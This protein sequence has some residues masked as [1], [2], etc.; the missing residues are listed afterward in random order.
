MQ[1]GLTRLFDHFWHDVSWSHYHI[2]I[3]R[4]HQNV[5]KK[6]HCAYIISKG[7]IVFCI[8]LKWDEKYALEN[9]CQSIEKSN[10]AK[11]IKSQG[12]TVDRSSRLQICIQ[13]EGA[14]VRRTEKKLVYKANYCH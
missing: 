1:N 5:K 10:S 11:Y 14:K 8:V 3:Y 9:S 7:F 4:F 6:K 12:K 2:L 13:S